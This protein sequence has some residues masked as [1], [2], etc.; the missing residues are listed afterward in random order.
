MYW[1]SV[2]TLRSSAGRN[3]YTGAVSPLM[4]KSVSPSSARTSIVPSALSW[5]LARMYQVMGSSTAQSSSGVLESVA[6]GAAL[7]P[8][9]SSWGVPVVVL[10]REKRSV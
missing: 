5:A 3:V 10:P 2:H 6:S 7:R 8:A 1:L 4:S 9:R